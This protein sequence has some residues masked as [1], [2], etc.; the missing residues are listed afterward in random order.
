MRRNYRNSRTEC[1]KGNYRGTRHRCSSNKDN[2][3]QSSSNRRFRNRCN[4]RSSK[5]LVIV[6][7]FIEIAV[8]TFSKT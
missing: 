6:A 8:G 7:N 1:S 5:N 3:W 2:S 4:P